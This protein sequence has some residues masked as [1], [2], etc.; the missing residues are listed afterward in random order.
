MDAFSDYNQIPMYEPDQEKTA[1]ITNRG[2]YYYKVMLFGLKNVGA[3]YQWLVNKIF[4]SV[5]AG[6]YLGHLR[7]T[8]TVLRRHQMRLNPEK[9]AFGV[10]LGKFIGF[11]VQQQGIEAN[12]DKIRAVLDMKSPSTIKKVQ[13]LVGRVATLS[14]FISKATDRCKPFFKVFK[15]G[16]KFRWTPDCEEAFQELKGYL[17]NALLLAKLE[18]GEVF[19]LYLAVSEHA[20]SS[21]LLQEDD[22]GVQRPIYYTSKVMVDAEKRYPTSEKIILA[23]VVSARKLRLYFQAHTIAV[24]RSAIKAQ[25]IA[26]FIAE[27]AN[28]SSGKGDLRYLLD[29]PPTDEEEQVWKIYVDG[30]SN[31]HRSGA[32]VII[33]DPNKVKICYALQFGFKAS[34]NEAEYEAIIAGL[35]MSKALGANM[36]HVKSDSQLVVERVPQLENSEADTLAKMASLGVAQSFGPITTE[37]IP[38]PSVGLPESLEVGSLSNKVLWMEPIIR[39]LKDGDLPSDKSEARRLK[40]KAVQYCLIQDTLYRRG[41][42]LLYLKCLGSDDTEYLMREIHEG[43]CGNHYGAQSLAQKALRQGY[44]WPTMWEDAKNMLLFGARIDNRFATPT[45]PQSNGQVKAVNKIIKGILKKKLEERKGAWVD[46]LPRVLWAYRT[47]QNTSTRETPFSLAFDVD[48][49]IPAEI[50]VPSHRVEYFDEAENTS[51]VAS[52]L[53]LV[54]KKRARAELRTAIYQHHILGL[55]EKRVR[56]RSF[57]KGDLV[58]RRVTQNTKVPCEGAFGANWEGPYRIDK[59]VGSGA[60]RL[61]HMDET[62]VRH[63]WNAAMHGNISPLFFVTSILECGLCSFIAINIPLHLVICNSHHMLVNYD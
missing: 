36:V 25:D 41:F 4:K 23:L 1:F 40:Y 3:T 46:E 19:L 10:T 28:D 13:S 29:T 34:N 56:H 59:H 20:T 8:F 50:G 54:A 32:G 6:E 27:F 11:M 16:K 26:D 61:L 15:T 9:C 52:D 51:L 43:I 45:H 42:T 12:P 60:Y 2:L 55:Y 14:R 18:P 38:E 7:D 5:H 31:S 33:I 58:L 63:P 35:R 44:Y 49:V 47:T 39:Y 48:A 24:P 17:V 57:K 53:D 30:S 22:N 62:I 21:V 37:Y